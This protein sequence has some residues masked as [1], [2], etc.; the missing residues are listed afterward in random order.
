MKKNNATILLVM[1]VILMSGCA[2]AIWTKRYVSDQKAQ[3]DLAECQYAEAEA[4]QYA[5]ANKN[6]PA[7]NPAFNPTTTSC[8]VSKGYHQERVKQ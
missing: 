3:R 1:T 4:N 7:Y 6:N 2:K 5:A 8:M